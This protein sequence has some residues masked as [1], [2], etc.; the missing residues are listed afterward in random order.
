MKNI[1]CFDEDHQHICSPKDLIDLIDIEPGFPVR[2][3]H[4]FHIRLY[5][6]PRD[7][8]GK[9]DRDGYK[10]N[11]DYPAEFH[12]EFWHFDHFLPPCWFS[13]F[14]CYSSDPIQEQS[15]DDVCVPRIKGLIEFEMKGMFLDGLNPKMG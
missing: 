15:C 2:G 1:I 6:G 5:L 7:L 4:G 10:S 3:N 11:N 13:I 9:D 14:L 12:Y 8:A